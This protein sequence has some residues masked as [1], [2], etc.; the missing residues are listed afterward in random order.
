MEKRKPTERKVAPRKVIRQDLNID[1][2]DIT[3]EDVEV[4]IKRL[5]K[6]KAPGPDKSTT[7]LYKYL[8]THN[9]KYIAILLNLLWQL[10]AVPE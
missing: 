5:K 6:N 8:F 2:G 3:I 10:E 1:E 9:L 4:I 7:E